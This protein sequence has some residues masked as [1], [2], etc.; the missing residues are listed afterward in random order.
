MKNNSN[1]TGREQV[2]EE[3]LVKE[4]LDDFK[5]RQQERKSFETQWELNMNFLMGNQYC[6]IGPSGEVEEYDKQ[7]YW[8]EREVYNHIA[9]IIE[10][11]LAKLINMKP[12]MTVVPASGD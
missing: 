6:S 4:V 10:S 1:Q 9:P 12:T 3:D 2:F 11:R 8:Q 7:F 5:T